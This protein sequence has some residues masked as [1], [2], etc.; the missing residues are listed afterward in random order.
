LKQRWRVSV[1]ALVRRAYDLGCISQAT[2]R[3]AFVQMNARN[4][5]KHERFEPPAEMP[6]MIANAIREL[7]SDLPLSKLADKLTLAEADLPIVR[8]IE[9][10]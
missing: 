9:A 7:G 1:Q 8:H 2:Y 3:R 10:T 4:E 5:R 6:M